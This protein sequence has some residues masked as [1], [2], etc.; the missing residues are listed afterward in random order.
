[1]RP[2]P[3][4]LIWLLVLGG[5][6]ACSEEPEKDPFV[7]PDNATTLLSGDSTKTWKLARRFN[8]GTRM[9]MGDRF[10]SY[11]ITYRADKTLQDNNGEQSDCGPT[12]AGTWKFARDK[13]GSPYLKWHSPQL[14]E[15]MNTDTPEKTFRIL[16]LQEDQLVLKYSHRQFSDKK[17][18]ITDVLVPQDA[19]IEDREFHW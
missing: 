11:R 4:Y 17:T 18:F 19:T 8:N 7:L 10:L 15:L 3:V 16:G 2:Y 6:C 12:L 9:N 13:S 1:M 5:L 14:P